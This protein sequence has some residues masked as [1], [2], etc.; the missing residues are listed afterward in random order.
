[1]KMT[2]KEERLRGKFILLIYWLLWL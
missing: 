1:M 2:K